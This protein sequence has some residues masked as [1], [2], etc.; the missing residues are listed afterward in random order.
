MSKI[1]VAIIGAGPSGLAVSEVLRS[2]KYAGHF[3]VTIYEANNYVGGKCHTIS[4]DDGLNYEVG[5]V[6]VSEHSEGYSSLIK[7]LDKY[8]IDRTIFDRHGADSSIYLNKAKP[9]DISKL[10]L[11]DLRTNPRKFWK[12]F[13]GYDD[14]INDYIHYSHS[15][16]IGYGRRPKTLNKNTSKL[17][18]HEVNERLS[19]VVQGYGYADFDDKKLSPPLLYYHQYIEAG[20]IE[21]PLH[22]IDKGTQNI[23]ST[24]AQGYPRGAIRLNEQVLGVRRD[25]FG[26]EVKTINGS[27]TYD[28]LVVATPLKPAI[29]F[30]DLDNDEKNFLSKMKHNHYVTVLC[31]ANGFDHGVTYSVSNCTAQKNLGRVMCVYKRYPNSNLMAMYL[32]TKTKNDE[33]IL[34]NVERSLNEDFNAKLLNRSEAK[35]YHWTDYFGHLDTRSLNEGWYDRFDQS[36]QGKNR[37]LYVSSGLHMETVGASVEYGTKLA[38]DYAKVWLNNLQRS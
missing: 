17:Y 5:A 37:T 22:K 12:I 34:N 27:E 13:K 14:F 25:S 18:R 32:Y 11:R 21:H 16:H 35:I 30:L 6:L 1:K 2:D 31:E 23:W 7:L 19:G 10:H 28:Y 15:R 3:D 29:K 26:V 8:K 38:K 9:T 4:N 33:S 20:E 36:F 24:I